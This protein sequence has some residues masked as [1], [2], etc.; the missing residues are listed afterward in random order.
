MNG[1][2][3]E[4]GEGREREKERERRGGFKEAKEHVT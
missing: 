2:D 4:E 3:E 1:V